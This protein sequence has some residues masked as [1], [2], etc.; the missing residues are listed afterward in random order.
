MSF[1]LILVFIWAFTGQLL[2]VESSWMITLDAGSSIIVGVVLRANHFLFRFLF[3]VVS[4]G[5]ELIVIWADYAEASGQVE[6]PVA[7]AIHALS[8]V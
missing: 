4:F 2:L 5:V 7:W 6:Y 1:I 3:T 8:T